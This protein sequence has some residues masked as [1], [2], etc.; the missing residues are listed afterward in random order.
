MSF[1]DI[2]MFIMALGILA[3]AFDRII[4][5]KLGL[6]KEFEDG[7]KNMG[8]IGLSVIG[9]ISFVSFNIVFKF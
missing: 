1:N 8:T 9:I 7:F 4:G 5:N 6:G 3:G 2:V